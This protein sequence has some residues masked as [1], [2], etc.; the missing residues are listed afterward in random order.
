M[1]DNETNG[2]ADRSRCRLC[3]RHTR[4]GTTAHHLIPRTCHRNK[5]FKK[6]YAREVMLRTIAVCHDCHRAVHRFVPSE[7]ELGKRYNTVE[8]LLAHPEIG[9][10]VAWVK[11]RK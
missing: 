7:K 2:I 3:G 4:R 10:F 1:V 5:W 8:L 9:K 6:N 11:H